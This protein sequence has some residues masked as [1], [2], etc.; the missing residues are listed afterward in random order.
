MHHQEWHRTWT[1]TKTVIGECL[2]HVSVQLLSFENLLLR[3][4]SVFTH[5]K[6]FRSLAVEMCKVNRGFSPE[7]L[8]YLLPLGQTCQYNLRNRSQFIIPS[9]KTVNHDFV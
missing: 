3:D 2:I 1:L 6:N 8:N 4:K 5:H 9:V 7:F